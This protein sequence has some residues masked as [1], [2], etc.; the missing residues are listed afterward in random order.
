MDKI[1]DIKT[2]VKLLKKKLK[3]SSNISI[4]NI[5]CCFN[6]ISILFKKIQ[7]CSTKISI[8]NQF[9]IYLLPVL[10]IFV[11]LL[12]LIHLYLFGE[13]LKF[14][15]YTVIKEEFLRYFLTDL[16]DIKS[17]L[18]K[19]RIKLFFEDFSNLA[20]FKIYFQE[21]NSYGLLNDDTEK[22]FQNISN[23][24]G[25]VYQSLEKFN[26]IFFIPNNLSEKYIDSRN[27]SLSEMAK[28]Y[29]Y[30]Y[31][32]IATES[33]KIGN[34]INQTFLISYEVGENNF[35]QGNELYFNFPR[36]TDEFI[37]NNNFFPYNNLIAPSVLK[38]TKCRNETE[39]FIEEKNEKQRENLEKQENLRNR[40]KKEEEEIKKDDYIHENWFIDFDCNYR[41]YH[42]ENDFKIN[43]FH[44]NE[45]NRGSINKTNVVTMQTY[46]YNSEKKIYIINIIFFIGQRILK[47]N[48]FEDSVFLIYN[49]SINNIKFSDDQTYVINNNDITE[50]AV[51]TQFD[52]YFHYGL[53]SKNN[54]FFSEGVFYDNIDI[55]ELYEPSERFST[56]DGFNFDIR[57]FSSFYLFIKLFEKSFYTK[58]S[59]DTDH[60]Y[61][62]IF[63]SSEHINE[64]CS[65]FDFKTYMG[66]L[67]SNNIDCFNDKNLLYYSK[68]NIKTLFSEG[69]TLPY[70]I[71]LPLYCIK[72]LKKDL[73]LDNFEIVD[74]LILPEKCQN[75]L[76]YY[77]NEIEGDNGEEV[78]KDLTGI[79]LR[80]GET[81]DEQLENQFFIFSHEKRSVN[82][83]LNF[84]KITIVNNFDIKK[85]L[86][87]FV[88]KMNSISYNFIL[89]IILG[90]V[91]VFI[92]ISFLLLFYIYSFSK[93]IYEYRNKA[94]YYL[95]KLANSKDKNESQNKQDENTILDDK[96][97]YE[98]FPLLFDE[99][100][101]DKDIEENELIDDLFKIYS[102]FYKLSENN[103]LEVLQ[104]KQ[105]NKNLFKIKIL[106][107]SN[108]LFKLLI[109]LAVYI[110]KF[111][112]NISI[113][114]D[115]YKDSK[116]IDNFMKSFS[117]K[118]NTTEEKEQF[119]YTKSI[120]KELLSTELITE[121]GFITNINFN[122]ITNINLNMRK[123]K[124]N[125]IQKAIF[126]KVEEMGRDKMNNNI[127]EK[128]VFDDFKVENIK[129]VFKNK[130]LVMKKIEDKFEQDDYLNLSKLESYF[131]TTLINSYY[132]YTKKIITEE[133]SY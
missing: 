106:N 15:F 110:P 79:S 102:N 41:S 122:Y 96:N 87:E 63:N 1:E 78:S 91:F 58:E 100:N 21:L 22:I 84:V 13:I 18:N 131:N 101:D 27:D 112:L 81:L 52:Q 105:N 73:D 14:D 35:I 51:S 5:C 40:E 6:Y 11:I 89:I 116:L 3:N 107:K 97:N 127:Y 7:Q 48:Q 93:V 64:I 103:L 26:T 28:L 130:N 53:S 75:N 2:K 113:D 30:F 129:I 19:K 44:L 17:D 92:A 49:H 77:E 94:Y 67:K 54:N 128:N 123:E 85:V 80:F 118:S 42:E 4:S 65:K 9:I 126:K 121:Y 72:N 20:F 76:L 37:Q 39:H 90:T 111:Q 108:E 59:M 114:Y 71:C 50:I 62:F 132:N 31:P 66:S 25:S 117:K 70:C 124:Q 36:I 10:I 33:N 95:K 16:D 83:E 69:L 99:S 29:Y 46:L 119:L 68:E 56:I 82:G 38:I 74:E 55:N 133:I 120:I 61:Y 43:Y 115:F 23:F 32:L 57:Y 104:N 98:S 47:D 86:V 12:I 45:N 109:K 60:I 24:N 88:E 34:F 125:Y 8:F